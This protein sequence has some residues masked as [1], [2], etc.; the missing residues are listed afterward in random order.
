MC[1]PNESQLE[2]EIQYKDEIEQERRKQSTSNMQPLVDYILNDQPK[3]N[4]EPVFK[5]GQEDS[6]ISSIYDQ[7]QN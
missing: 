4:D 7:S 5:K 1:P 3:K 2:E 6:I